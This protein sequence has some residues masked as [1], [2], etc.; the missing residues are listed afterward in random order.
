MAGNMVRVEQDCGVREAKC[1]VE[2]ERTLSGVVL[3]PVLSKEGTKGAQ[4]VFVVKVGSFWTK[5]T[6]CQNVREVGRGEG[7]G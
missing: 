7:E 4:V 1:G 6:I 5:Y 3:G 2:C